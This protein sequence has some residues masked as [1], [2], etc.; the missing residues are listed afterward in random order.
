MPTPLDYESRHCPRDVT[1][2]FASML[3]QAVPDAGRW[4]S[5]Y[6]A[7]TR[8]HDHYLGQ[9]AARVRVAPLGP[10][11]CAF[12]TSQELWYAWVLRELDN[13]EPPQPTGRTLLIDYVA[14]PGHE[15]PA[16]PCGVT[17][18]PDTYPHPARRPVLMIDL[19]PQ[20]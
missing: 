11:E 17:P 20:E 7:G 9:Y 19:G 13:D 14:R 12:D 18:L 4:W 6:L 10:G 2:L 15:V 8:V 3:R 5:C 16:R 1:P